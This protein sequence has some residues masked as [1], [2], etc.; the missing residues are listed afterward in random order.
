MSN[1]IVRFAWRVRKA[2]F[3]DYF[4]ERNPVLSAAGTRIKQT[5]L[6]AEKSVCQ[7]SRFPRAR[8]RPSKTIAHTGGGNISSRERIMKKKLSNALSP[9]SDVSFFNTFICTRA[10]SLLPASLCRRNVRRKLRA[11]CK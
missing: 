4:V 11:Y 2:Y 9:L 6:R 10:A 1:H 7:P 8:I 5:R 3:F